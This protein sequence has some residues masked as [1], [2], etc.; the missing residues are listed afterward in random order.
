MRV[1]LVGSGGRE[2]ALAWRIVKSPQLTALTV[3]GDNPGWPEG[4]TVAA[5]STPEQIVAV[6]RAASADLAVVGPEAPLAAGAADALIAAGIPCFGPQREAARLE[7]SKAFA[8]EIM[9]ATGVDTAAA[10]VVDRSDPTSV[11]AARE[12]CARG[13]VRFRYPRD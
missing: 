10:L 1:V 5:A 12:R 3:T 9:Q 4:V 13:R 8:K 6:A 11:A 2:A 7:S